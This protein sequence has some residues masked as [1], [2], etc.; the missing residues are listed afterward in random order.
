MESRVVGQ[1]NTVLTF[2][3]KHFVLLGGLA[4]EN[5][6]Q[7]L[8]SPYICYAQK[9]FSTTAKSRQLPT[10]HMYVYMYIHVRMLHI[11]VVAVKKGKSNCSINEKMELKVQRNQ[12]HGEVL[13]ISKEVRQI[14]AVGYRNTMLSKW[15][16]L[17]CETATT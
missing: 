17:P 14:V 4:F 10:F 5:A 9:Q 11:V 12:R 16:C 13:T 6:M 2:G 1:R 8:K 3:A 7:A 15:R